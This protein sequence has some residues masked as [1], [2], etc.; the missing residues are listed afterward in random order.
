MRHRHPAGRS[1][2]REL[3]PP[4][5]LSYPAGW[6]VG[7]AA[8]A[9][10]LGADE[11]D[12]GAEDPEDDDDCVGVGVG[13]GQGGSW[14]LNTDKVI[15]WVCGNSVPAAGLSSATRPS[16]DCSVVV[17][18]IGV[19]LTLQLAL[20]RLRTASA[21]FWPRTSGIGSLPV[22]TESVIV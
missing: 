14:K 13:V 10:D 7:A 21:Y 22:D 5:F 9:G 12:G 16:F 8:A 20:L 3:I 15:C 18:K 19:G 17:T 6:Q 11:D 1:S 2:R 4:A